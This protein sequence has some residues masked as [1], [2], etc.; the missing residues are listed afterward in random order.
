MTNPTE[1]DLLSQPPGL[2]QRGDAAGVT[3]SCEGGRFVLTIRDAAGAALLAFGPYG[4]DDVLAVWRSLCDR[5]GLPM[6]QVDG[7]GDIR[8]LLPH[9]GRIALGAAPD[10]SRLA[11]LSGR[12]PR[13]LTRRKP[14]R[15][16]GRPLVH[17]EP[18]IAGQAR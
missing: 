17:R 4:D 9:L 10:R 6:A 16:P 15:M 11:V 7:R 1:A 5:S 8:P 12:R 13:F 2:I 14:S 3:I 18:E